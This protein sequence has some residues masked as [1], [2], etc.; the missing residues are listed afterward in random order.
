MARIYHHM[1]IK[2]KAL[3]NYHRFGLFTL[4]E[5]TLEEFISEYNQEWSRI[6][7]N[8]TTWSESH[9]ADGFHAL[10]ANG[11]QLTHTEGTQA[12]FR[13]GKFGRRPHL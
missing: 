5:L 7:R 9:H 1:M 13:S 12:E 3:G 2:G 10:V 4:K 6:Y 8:P 11:V